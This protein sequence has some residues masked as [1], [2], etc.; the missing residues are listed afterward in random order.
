MI[1][2][3]FFRS[4]VAMCLL[5]LAFF[6]ESQAQLSFTANTTNGCS[7]LIANYTASA[8]GAVSYSWNL[9]NNT[10]SSVQ[11]P[12]VTYV[13]GG[14]FNV[15]LTVSYADGSTQ[16]HFEAGYIE[17]FDPP[18]VDFSAA[19]LAICSGNDVTFSNSSTQGSG[20]I[21]SWLWDFGDG[22]TDIQQAPVHNYTLAGVFP[23]T[24]VATDINGCSSLEQK[25]ALVQVN[26]TP[27][28]DFSANNTLSCTT[29]FP[30]NF[31][32]LAPA[33]G[34]THIWNLGNGA[35]PIVSNPTTSYNNNGNYT[36]THIVTD[37]I[38]CSDTVTKTNYIQVGSPN[39]NIQ[40]SANTICAGESV[41]F[42]CGSAPGS[43]VNWTFGNGQVSANCA[44]T[45]FYVNPGTFIASVT[46]TDPS[47][48]TYNSS[49]PITVN[50]NPVAD[51]TIA[52]TVLCNPAHV[53]SF[54]ALGNPANLYSWTFGDGNGGAGQTVSHTYPNLPVMT[55]TGQPYFWDVSLTVKNVFGCTSSIAQTAAISTGQTVAR[56]DADSRIGCAPR[57]VDFTDQSLSNSIVNSWEWDFG[58]PGGTSTLQNPSFTYTNTGSYDVRLIIGT[59]HGCKDTVFAPGFI[60]AGDTPVADFFP[61]TTLSCASDPIQMFNLSVGAD[62]ASWI[63]GDGKTSSA[64]EP[65]HQFVDTGYISIM[66]IAMDRGCPD[67][68]FVD[69]AVYINA[70]IAQLTP[71]SKFG[72]DTPFTV[73]FT[74]LSLGAETWSWDFDDGSP[75]STIP[76]PVH[77]YTSEGLY[78]PKLVVENLTNGCIDSMFGVI[79]VEAIEASFAVD[80]T[81]GCNPVTVIFTDLSYKAINYTWTFG[82]GGSSGSNA[83]GHTYT[84]P[85]QFDVSLFVQNSI[86]C[87]DDTTIT[88]QVSVYEPQIAFQAIP[89]QGCAPL[90][91]NFT[92]N[93]TSP[94]PVVTWQWN[95]GPPGATSALQSPSYTYID[96]GSWDVGLTATDSVGCTNS[97]VDLNA[98]FVSQPIPDFFAQYPINCPNNPLTFTNT[99][100]GSGLNYSW[101]FGDG[102]PASGAFNPT[103]TYT[104]P[105]N[106][107]VSL[108]VTDFQG[109]DSTITLV[110]YITIADPT[111]SLTPDTTSA[112]CPP[113]LV[114]F[115]GNA[116]SP[117][118]FNMWSWDFGD[119]G[120]SAGQNPSH[121]YVD[122]GSYTITLTASSPAGCS[123]SFTAPS[124]I[125]INGPT[126]SFTIA[127][128]AA[129]PGSPLTFT[130]TSTNATI[131][132][133]DFNNGVLQTG[134]TVNYAYPASGVYLP[135][136]ILE[137]AGGCVIVIPNTQPVN[138]HPVPQADF[139]QSQT[140][141]CDTGTVA[142]TNTSVSTVPVSG[143]N[144]DFGL[145]LGTSLQNNPSFF[146]GNLGTYDVRLIVENLFGCADTIIKPGLV[147]IAEPPNAELSLS[148]TIGCAPFSVT[149][150]DISIIGSSTIASRQWASG[151]TPPAFSS[152]PQPTFIYSQPGI[153]QSILQVTDQNGCT[154]SDTLALEVLT[155][156]LANFAADD[157]FGCAPKPIQF[158]TLTPGIVDWEWDFGDNT[159]KVFIDDPLHTYF[160]DGTY[161][162][163]L[164]V[165]DVEGC[166]DTL[167]KPQYIK[168]DHPTADFVISDSVICP[169]EPLTFSDLSISD[170]SL[171]GWTWQFGNGD[172]SAAQNPSYSYPA[173]GLYGVSL[174]VED[175][176]GCEDSLSKP[177]QVRVRVDNTPIAPPIRFV[178]VMSAT[179]IRIVFDPYENT[180]GDFGSY[181]LLQDDG[182]GTW[183]P[184]FV[185]TDINDTKFVQTGLSTTDQVYCYRLEV[186]NFCERA[187]EFIQSDI[188]CSILLE[189]VSLVDA[190]ELNW[191]A[192]V[193]WPVQTY[194]IYRVNNYDPNNVS[195]VATVSGD[196]T[197]WTDLDMFCYDAF[198]Y[199][200]KAIQAG[201]GN[202]TS[203]S[204]IRREAPQ[205]FGPPF[206][207]DIEV[208]TVEAD[209]F[210]LVKWMD[211]P[212]GE[213]LVE[214]IVEKNAGNGFAFWHS[215]SINDPLREKADFEVDVDFQSYAYQIYVVD[216]CGDVSPAGNIGKT[217]LL[218]AERNEGSVFLNWT[219][220]EQW[221]SGVDRYQIELFNESTGEFQLV[222]SVSG[223]LLEYIDNN[224]ELPQGTYC[225]RIVATE[226]NGSRVVSVSNESCITVDPL[227]YFPNAFSPNGDGYNEL[228]LIKGAYIDRFNLE[229]YNRWGEKIFVTTNQAT[230]W[231]GKINGQVEAPEGTYVFKVLGVGYEGEEIL[232]SGTVTLFR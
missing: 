93:T 81:F 20:V 69:S 135:L 231:D 64:L 87:T 116:L 198:V 159:P 48:C 202:E 156:P 112:D 49:Q 222:N 83:P 140:V 46:I 37:A 9:G 79:R 179:D 2:L 139:T 30:V 103:H 95:F 59:I 230:G 130:A 109:C 127:P 57:L 101:D 60:V 144:W 113:L 178:T 132:T 188:H 200:I 183:T 203:W 186:T 33:P 104:L 160:A 217:I 145:G 106:Y 110:N 51:F 206:Q 11:S 8:P 220:Y 173:S 138:I 56:M 121:I 96:P 190:I 181:R 153:Y 123:A 85:G 146:F 70:P 58:V 41:S 134:Q 120:T 226:G 13:T 73:I 117:H 72:C 129:C 80:T 125:N 172:L 119:G 229:I 176:F 165:T 192:Y 12:S 53:A 162:V 63:F 21:T 143:I 137:D 34:T 216:T 78:N 147:V 185:S 194:E 114:N 76:N 219:P 191:T 199:R 208:A 66:L 99:S 209:S 197:T 189:T 232:R 39:I 174:K 161:T 105:G 142:F 38:G 94:A 150:T 215:Q 131:F 43:I 26:A 155:P 133:W 92:N 107:T 141:L 91:V 180:E 148:D 67:T 182:S 82:D 164:A 84:D 22:T 196:L 210:V 126:G 204:N 75:I 15:S 45:V 167:V 61:D 228:F 25:N 97:F 213:N 68:L 168:L 42:N 18:T 54:T 124:L 218:R 98:V 90:L 89:G 184:V 71:F 154:D 19:P 5:T 207:M 149:F 187:S 122:P 227:L 23:V 27:S 36:V 193:G 16:T 50:P 115:T 86:G 44:S 151:Q 47:G 102:S 128:T 52:D 118:P 205:H 158:Q 3:R 224:T 177:R 136:L 32:T 225:Y 35:S 24:L 111:I 169:G 65:L 29:P 211:V 170:T 88:Q 40:V 10:F 214:V 163:T 1:P 175:F 108:T 62:S 201:G 171:V 17:V 100:S 28:A 31:V 223:G 4:L 74:D 195:L 157:S 221:D 7:P 152:F 55:N 212:P 77:T 6:A 14:L 166:R